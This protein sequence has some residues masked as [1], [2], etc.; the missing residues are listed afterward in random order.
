MARHPGSSNPRRRQATGVSIVAVVLAAGVVIDQ[1]LPEPAKEANIAVQGAAVA[2]EDFRDGFEGAGDGGA[3]VPPGAC[4]G[5]P[6]GWARVEKTWAQLFGPNG[7]PPR[8]FHQSQS[9]PAPLPFVDRSQF[10]STPFTMLPG[11]WVNFYWDQVQ[12]RAPYYTMPRPANAMFVAISPC[13]GGDFRAPNQADPD[14][15]ARPGCRKFENSASLIF[16]TGQNFDSGA[17]CNL[18]PGVT[19]WLHMIAADPAA[20]IEPGESSCQK[21]SGGCDVGVVTGGN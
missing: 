2:S 7:A 11:K 20:G 5:A 16:G 6:P 18:S 12:T 3:P 1:N 9:W 10:T 17:G 21:P 15:F 4:Q 8:Q 14:P 19:Y 13:A